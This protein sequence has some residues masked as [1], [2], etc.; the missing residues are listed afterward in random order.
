VTLP[1][2][3]EIPRSAICLSPRKNRRSEGHEYL[4]MKRTKKNPQDRWKCRNC[5]SEL[6]YNR[7]VGAY[8]SNCVIEEV[9]W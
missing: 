3:I 6:V 1:I 4:P 5:K 9:P 8:L 2:H 7:D